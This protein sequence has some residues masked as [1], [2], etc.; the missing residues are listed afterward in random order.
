MINWSHANFDLFVILSQ[1]FK[2][3]KHYLL[4]HLTNFNSDFYKKPEKIWNFQRIV[5][6]MLNG[7]NHIKFLTKR[8][9]NN[10]PFKFDDIHEF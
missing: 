2:P 6:N 3:I 8:L 10:N 4:Y 1:S 5:E 9:K 7:H